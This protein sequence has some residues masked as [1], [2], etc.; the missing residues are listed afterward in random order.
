MKPDPS[1]DDCST[2][3][4]QFLWAVSGEPDPREKT[5]SCTRHP[6]SVLHKGRVTWSLS[7]CSSCSLSQVGV[8]PSAVDTPSPSLSMWQ[9]GGWGALSHTLKMTEILRMSCTPASHCAPYS[10]RFPS[11]PSISFSCWWRHQRLV[12][13]SEAGGFG[14][15]KR[16]GLLMVASQ[17]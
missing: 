4:S 15:L 1:P 8:P 10:P 14:H 5:S 7:C 12:E 11:L 6:A 13:A 9:V 3:R 2:S 17:H 16:E